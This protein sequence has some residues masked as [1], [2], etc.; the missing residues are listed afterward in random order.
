MLD[1]FN[2]AMIL[3]FKMPILFD[4]LYFQE[5]RREG[6]SLSR[7]SGAWRRQPFLLCSITVTAARCALPSLCAYAGPRAPQ[8]PLPAGTGAGAITRHP[9]SSRS[10]EKKIPPVVQVSAKVQLGSASFQIAQRLLSSQPFLSPASLAELKSLLFSP[11]R[12]HRQ[13]LQT[14]IELQFIPI[15]IEFILN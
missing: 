9:R 5:N 15:M 1:S 6:G 8:Q 7:S 10:R 12:S 3:I 4:L 2:R 11:G 13:N 14:R